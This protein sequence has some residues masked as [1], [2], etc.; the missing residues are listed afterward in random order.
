[1]FGW[2]LKA[3]PAVVRVQNMRK[4]KKIMEICERHDWKVIVGI[5]PDK[6]ENISDF[7]K[8]QKRFGPDMQTMGRNDPCFCGSG[9]KFKQCCD[10]S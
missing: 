4:A 6:P 9:R 2:I 1:M 8:L 10:W 7:I 3:R 5:E